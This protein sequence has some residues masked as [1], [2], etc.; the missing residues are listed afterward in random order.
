MKGGPQHM[1]GP[2]HALAGG[3]PGMR[4]PWG[5][6]PPI[7]A[8]KSYLSLTDEQVKSVQT[9]I[10]ERNKKMSET[11]REV[12][13]KRH[14]LMQSLAKPAGDAAA[15]RQALDEFQTTRQKMDVV[16]KE[17]HQK[18]TGVLQPDQV[19]KLNELEKAAEMQ[20]AIREAGA[21]GLMDGP[22]PVHG[23]GP[24]GPGPWGPGA[25]D[26]MR[27]GSGVP[28]APPVPLD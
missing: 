7:D 15:S 25:M 22:G 20:R 5:G 28:A 3:A 6:P 2:R 13:A 21:M 19:Q 4:P 9:L 23:P 27:G 17:F 14:A 26:R 11:F 16:K 1:M 8:L 24:V 12:A 18:L 10:E